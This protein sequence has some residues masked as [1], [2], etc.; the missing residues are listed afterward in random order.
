MSG[1]PA[2][3]GSSAITEAPLVWYASP[4]W[5]SA[6]RVLSMGCQFPHESRYW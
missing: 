4:G 2:V 3:A 5:L 6:T 1:P